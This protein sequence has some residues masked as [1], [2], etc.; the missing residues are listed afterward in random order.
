MRS[1]LV[2]FLPVFFSLIAVFYFRS[3]VDAYFFNKPS[4]SF[5]ET[6]S[7]S[8]YPNLI[9]QPS[10]E[11]IMLSGTD[12]GGVIYVFGSSELSS[13]IDAQ[14]YRFIS[15]HLKNK[16][17]AV[18]H[19]GNQCFSIYSQL[20]AHEE[21]LEGAPIFIILSPG[22]FAN[23]GTSSECFLEYN[24]TSMMNAILNSEKNNEFKKY[25]MKRVADMYTEL[26]NPDVSFR[27]LYL[28]NIANK[29]SINHLFLSPLIFADR[30]LQNAKNRMYSDEKAKIPFRKNVIVAEDKILPWDSLFASSKKAQ[31]ESVTNNSWGI[32]N[33]Y[34]STHINGNTSEMKINQNDEN[35]EWQDFIMLVRML[36]EKKANASF[37][38]LPM[39]P[40]YYT[41][42]KE[43]TPFVFK[44]HAELVNRGFPCLNM[45]NDD[46]TTFEKPLLNDVMH[47]SS[48]GL[49][50]VDWFLVN[51]YKLTK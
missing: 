5:V 29:N 21:K 50:K 3:S 9:S 16:V 35:I 38:I 49:F 7:T 18:G 19:A 26:V 27:L 32:N 1:L 8:Y 14:P 2:C 31:E 13:Q 33:E 25:E 11:Q 45:W 20:L 22:W 6:T 12:S 23:N 43:I 17:K 28:E 24:S 36:K 37:M 42:S 4:V 47:L 46:T 39:N 10:L 48:Y 40:F 30:Y 15:K 41:N 44:M 51:T 34:Y